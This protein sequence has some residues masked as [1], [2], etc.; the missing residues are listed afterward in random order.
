M[1]SFF[2][3]EREETFSDYR[4]G[5]SLYQPP[6]LVHDMLRTMLQSRYVCGHLRANDTPQPNNHKVNMRQFSVCQDHNLTLWSKESFWWN[7]WPGVHLS[8]VR[9]HPSVP[10]LSSYSW[11]YYYLSQWHSRLKVLWSLN[12]RQ[13]NYCLLLAS[14]NATVTLDKNQL[15]LT[16]FLQHSCKSER[17]SPSLA[18][19]ASQYRP[20]NTCQYLPYIA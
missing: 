3:L 11:S 12:H 7:C 5:R 4:E 1:F 9:C 17:D 16:F 13:D 15:K 19:T 14:H 2:A 20:A 8:C 10:L 18:Y 6:L